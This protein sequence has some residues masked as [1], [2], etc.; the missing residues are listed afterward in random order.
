MAAVWIDTLSRDCD[1]AADIGAGPS[2]SA[3][4]SR[5]T[6]WV[7]RIE[8]HRVPLGEPLHLVTTRRIGAIG[9]LERL[10]EGDSSATAAPDRQATRQVSVDQRVAFGW[11]RTLR[12]AARC[13]TLPREAR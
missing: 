3:E 8:L 4:P 13:R 9:F 7:H 12:T 11:T 2:V 10:Y 1:E 6:V 5:K